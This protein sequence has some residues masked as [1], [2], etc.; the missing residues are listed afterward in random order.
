MQPRVRGAEWVLLPP[1]HPSE[2]GWLV[3]GAPLCPSPPRHPPAHA[4]LCSPPPRSAWEGWQHAA[5]ERAALQACWREE[6]HF[7]ALFFPLRCPSLVCECRD[8]KGLCP[9]AIAPG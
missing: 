2:Q 6:N 1:W 7:F 3:W 4:G 8:L 9:G 5:E